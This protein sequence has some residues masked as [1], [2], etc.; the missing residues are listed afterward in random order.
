MPSGEPIAKKLSLKNIN[1]STT[2]N[3]TIIIVNAH[4]DVGPGQTYNGWNKKVLEVHFSLNQDRSLGNETPKGG[5][6]KSYDLDGKV[7]NDRSYTEGYFCRTEA[8]KFQKALD[9][10]TLALE[11]DPKKEKA[12]EGKVHCSL[13]I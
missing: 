5:C 3:N 7:V 4:Y 1:Y 13:I 11:C 10:A 6:Y 2:S 8:K 12:L 9:E